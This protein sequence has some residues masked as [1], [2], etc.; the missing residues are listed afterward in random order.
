MRYYLHP[1]FTGRETEAEKDQFVQG[2][3]ENKRQSWNW[4]NLMPLRCSAV[5]LKLGEVRTGLVSP[6]LNVH[7]TVHFTCA[8]QQDVNQAEREVTGIKTK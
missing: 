5:A 8:H 3:T 6:F 1:H 4:P 7:L 2:H